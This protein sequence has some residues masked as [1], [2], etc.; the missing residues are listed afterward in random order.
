MDRGIHHFFQS[1]QLRQRQDSLIH[2]LLQAEL[3]Q[4]IER[5]CD[6]QISNECLLADVGDF[7]V[8]VMD[9]LSDLAQVAVHGNYIRDYWDD[10]R[11][12]LEQEPDLHTTDYLNDKHEGL[13]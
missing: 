13:K 3:P 8:A 1:I 11:D 12:I 5:H 4:I 10:R 6:G 9:I 7:L 2:P